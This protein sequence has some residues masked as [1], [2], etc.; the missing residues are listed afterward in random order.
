[1]LTKVELLPDEKGH[2]TEGFGRN[3][4]R[5]WM[6]TTNNPYDHSRIVL[7]SPLC[8]K[9]GHRDPLDRNSFI[10][11][12]VAR[13]Q[14]PK[15]IN[16]LWIITTR[17]TTEV[18]IEENPLAM[19]ADVDW[20][21]EQFTAHRAFDAKGEPILNTA[22]DLLL[23]PYEDSR[24]VANVSKNLSA[25]PR[26]LF[27]MNNVI[28]SSSFVI[29]GVLFKRRTLM[30][31]RL[32]IGRV[33]YTVIFGSRVAYRQ[34]SYQLHFRPDGWKVKHPNVGF[35]E[36]VEKARI[37]YRS[38]RRMRIDPDTGKPTKEKRWG[39]DRIMVGDPPEYPTEPQWLDRDGKWI[40]D[41]SPSE[42]TE[43]EVDM[44]EERNFSVLP[45]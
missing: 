6:G 13:R 11:N 45:R 16:N 32:K 38:G 34:V 9:V 35:N 20:L 4:T 1:M 42:M 31:K 26:V 36:R 27:S 7:D 44:Y 14:D 39:K 17:S 24:W 21:S 23:L 40:E 5:Q 8:P 10:A 25:P 19:P 43:V 33:K 29:D 41:P 2:R 3:Y 37:V 15:D 18:D 12:V 22:R 28:N 30:C